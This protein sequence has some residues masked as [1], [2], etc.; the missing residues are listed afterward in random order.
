MPDLAGYWPLGVA[1]SLSE[2][3]WLPSRDG[4]LFKYDGSTVTDLSF[5]QPTTSDVFD[6]EYIIPLDRLLATWGALVHY[7]DDG[8]A[9]FTQVDPPVQMYKMVYNQNLDITVGIKESTGTGQPGAFYSY[10]G[11]SWTAGGISTPGQITFLWDVIWSDY[12]NKFVVGGSKGEVYLSSDGINWS[13]AHNLSG[14]SGDDVILASSDELGLLVGVA[15]TANKLYTSPDGVTWTQRTIP[16]TTKALRDVD[17]SSD[18]GMFVAVGDDAT[19]MTSTNGT[20]W[21]SRSSSFLST[22]DIY[23]VRY[24]LDRFYATNVNSAS[25]KTVESLDGVTWT[26]RSTLSDNEQPF[27]LRVLSSLSTSLYG[28][29]LSGNQ[30][31]LEL[32][33]SSPSA[34]SKP[35]VNSETVFTGLDGGTQL[36]AAV[37]LEMNDKERTVEWWSDLNTGGGQVIYQE[38]DGSENVF[39]VE[40]GVSGGASTPTITYRS[41]ELGD[42]NVE[43]FDDGGNYQFYH[44]NNIWSTQDYIVANRSATVYNDMEGVRL[45]ELS[46]DGSNFVFDYDAYIASDPEQLSLTT[47][48]VIFEKAEMINHPSPTL[49]TDIILTFYATRDRGGSQTSGPEIFFIGK[50]SNLTKTPGGISSNDDK[51]VKVY[52]GPNYGSSS[53]TFQHVRVGAQFYTIVAPDNTVWLLVS[54]YIVAGGGASAATQSSNEQTYL[55][56]LQI[57]QIVSNGSGGYTVNSYQTLDALEFDG[58]TVG[59]EVGRAVRAEISSDGVLFVVHNTYRDVNSPHSNTAYLSAYTLSGSTWVYEDSSTIVSSSSQTSI[60]GPSHWMEKAGAGSFGVTVYEL[61]SGAITSSTWDF[62]SEAIAAGLLTQDD[63]DNQDD[64]FLTAS[65]IDDQ[66]YM[67]LTTESGFYESPPTSGN[68]RWT[69]SIVALV[70]FDPDTQTFDSDGIVEVRRF[71]D[72]Q[73]LIDD[74]A[75]QYAGVG[76]KPVSVNMIGQGSIMFGYEGFNFSNTMGGETFSGVYVLYEGYEQKQVS[77]NPSAN[78]SINHDMV[79]FG[80]RRAIEHY[81][82]G[83][84]SSGSSITDRMNAEGVDSIII[85][86]NVDGELSHVA[87]WNTSIPAEQA[88]K[89]YA[90]SSESAFS[91]A[92]VTED[93]M[94][95]LGTDSYTIN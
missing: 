67:T 66:Y 87:S 10:D 60:F 71:P 63:I 21:T 46:W 88:E 13:S 79:V 42:Q 41:D 20:S 15:D 33:G 30:Q 1:E 3:L 69:T 78:A 40:M 45:M 16:I 62:S 35:Y 82:N 47:H 65:A 9:T 19:I 70:P 58:V 86:A 23:H 73:E 18:L 92:T 12:L 34:G 57:G 4:G 2:V 31:D 27:N 44:Q 48:T 89:R 85:G 74:E 75:G 32:S 51:W 53:T 54:Q 5:G 55:P 61:A 8:G 25:L 81:H 95:T 37:E 39:K 24:Y 93:S 28:D 76:L 22:D 14:V 64:F 59:D 36:T 77:L 52:E 49:D 43:N 6:V 38:F 72:T 50:A 80:G 56:K 83:A 11:I 90:L 26:T 68:F 17:W 84:Y 94:V 29:D 91:T 7:S